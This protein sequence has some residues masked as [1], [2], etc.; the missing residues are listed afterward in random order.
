MDFARELIEYS[1]LRQI[2]KPLDPS[3]LSGVYVAYRRSLSEGTEVFHNNIR[4]RWR[5]GDPE[6]VNAM[7]TWASYAE[8][9]RNAA[10]RSR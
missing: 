7:Q 1:R 10:A 4:E 8:Q 6:I 5:G 9:G 2:I 3:L